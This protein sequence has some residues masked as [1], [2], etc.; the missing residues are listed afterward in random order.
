MHKHCQGDAR[1]RTDRVMD[2]GVSCPLVPALLQCRQ[3]GGLARPRGALEQACCTPCRLAL[4]GPVQGLG[5]EPL[6]LVDLG[7]TPAKEPCLVPIV[8]AGERR[9]ARKVRGAIRS[10]GHDTDTI[11]RR[12]REEGRRLRREFSGVASSTSVMSGG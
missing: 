6:D 10:T 11:A 1:R 2:A 5:A 4:A 12:G 3:Q 7:T 9:K 8:Q